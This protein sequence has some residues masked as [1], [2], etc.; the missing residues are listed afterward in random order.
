M[1]YLFASLVLAV[2]LSAGASLPAAADYGVGGG[3]SA[4][5][6]EGIRF[7][8]YEPE[9]R[10]QRRRLASV[11]YGETYYYDDEETVPPRQ[12]AKSRHYHAKRY[13]K[14]RGL[15]SAKH[16]RRHQRTVRRPA[17]QQPKA[18]QQ[19]KPVQQP[20]AAQQPKPAERHAA[21]P[22]APPAPGWSKKSLGSDGQKRKDLAG[23]ALKAARDAAAKLP[24]QR[25]VA[26]YYWQGQRVA[27]GGWFNPN[28][29]TAAHRT[30]PFGTRVRVTHL[31]NG[32]SVEVKINDR[33]PYIAG[34]IIDLSKGAAS[35]IGMTGQGLA[36]VV[37]EVLG[38]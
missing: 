26:S 7:R 23:E 35:V 12:R 17:G 6:S 15:R 36:R 16:T 10:P 18:A 20:K 13:S 4:N 5:W 22:A 33:G 32:R 1:R 27:S 37:V 24:G 34:R 2:L 3:A 21:V 31:G 38:R 11:S 25:G 14:R 8:H 28:G 29:L 30:L 19:P 9:E